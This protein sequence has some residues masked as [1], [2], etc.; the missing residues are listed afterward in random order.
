[1]NLC[2]PVTEDLGL[3]SPV[4]AHFGS[5]PVFLLVDTESGACRPLP[6]RNLLHEHG[7]CQPLRSLEG[8]RVDGVVV[9]GIGMGALRKLQAA[10]IDVFRSELPTVE[11]TLAAFKAG[12]LRPVTPATACGHHGHGPH[13]PGGGPHGPCH[14]PGRAGT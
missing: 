13:G 6:N 10:G 1:M 14:G 2:I 7:M 4:S 8:Q 11:T 9:G 5:A 12:S 3:Q